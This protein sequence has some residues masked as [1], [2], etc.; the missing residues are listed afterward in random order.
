MRIVD[1]GLGPINVTGRWVGFYRHT[2]ERLGTFPI[3][4]EIRQAGDRIMGQMYDQITDRSE[5][6]DLIAQAGREDISLGKKL[7]LKAVIR[8]IGVGEVTVTFRLPETSDIAGAVVGDLVTFTKS[9]LGAY[10]VRWDV[11]GREV[12]SLTRGG[13]RV[14]YSGRLDREGGCIAGGWAIR[15]R[16]LLGRF[17]PPEARGRFE[18]YRKS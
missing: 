15:R 17:L 3:T 11:R 8:R 1:E 12:G 2:S 9:Y 18:L 5:L 4:A 10:Q 6:L 7:R 13:H 14:H 16:G